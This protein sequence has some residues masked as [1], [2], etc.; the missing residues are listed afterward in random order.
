MGVRKSS[1]RVNKR[2]KNFPSRIP[3][4]E[5]EGSHVPTNSSD[6][7]KVKNYFLSFGGNP[8]DILIKVT[9]E[10]QTFLFT[11]YLIS[12]YGNQ[13]AAGKIWNIEQ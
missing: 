4:R 12:V 10:V 8:R 3:R 7:S 13:N 2:N 11:M 9:S 1:V 6:L 5:N